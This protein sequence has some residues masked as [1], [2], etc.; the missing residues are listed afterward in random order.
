M[1]R[2]YGIMLVL[3]MSVMFNFGFAKAADLGIS[4]L[5]TYDYSVSKAGV[6]VQASAENLGIFVIPVANITYVDNTYTRYAVGLDVPVFKTGIFGLYGTVAGT[7]QDS[8]IGA[9]GF[10]VAYGGKVVVDVNKSLAFTAGYE[11][12][13]GEKDIKSFDGNNVNAG[14]L[15]RF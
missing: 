2:F 5:G 4:A 11:R 1:K 6:R 14:I 9:N 10:G 8:A 13:A 12:F 15:V 3:M 7:Y